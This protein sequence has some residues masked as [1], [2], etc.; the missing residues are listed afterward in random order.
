[1]CLPHFEGFVGSGPLETIALAPQTAMG[2]GRFG[3][4]TFCFML[5][6]SAPRRRPSLWRRLSGTSLFRC[7]SRGEVVL[8]VEL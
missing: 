6:G 5:L 7:V 8:V 4:Q 2:S 3:T 1:M